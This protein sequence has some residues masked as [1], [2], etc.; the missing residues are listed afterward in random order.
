MPEALQNHPAEEIK[1]M[2]TVSK[3]HEEESGHRGWRLLT[4][5]QGSPRSYKAGKGAGPPT[6]WGRHQKLR[7]MESEIGRNLS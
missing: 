1:I 2:S 7:I 3:G 4:T 5:E 6:T